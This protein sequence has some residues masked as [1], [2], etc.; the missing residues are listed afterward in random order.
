MATRV[1]HTIQTFQHETT[2]LFCQHTESNMCILAQ[3]I[4]FEF[5]Q[6]STS[7]GT[8]L[9]HTMAKLLLHYVRQMCGPN[10]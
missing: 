2:R 9:I 1:V 7:R 8:H 10:S 4:T 5:N 6:T 3:S